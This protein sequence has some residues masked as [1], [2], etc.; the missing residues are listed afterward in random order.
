MNQDF[1]KYSHF[2][3]WFSCSYFINQFIQLTN[4]FAVLIS[5]Q[6]PVSIL[7]NDSIYYLT[8]M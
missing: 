1:S 5:F 6:D 7:L 2:F 4:D 8:N 3:S